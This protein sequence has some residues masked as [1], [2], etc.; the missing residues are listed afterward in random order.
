MIEENR[1]S[2]Q[3]LM[4]EFMGVNVAVVQEKVDQI[5][6]LKI[7]NL[8]LQS[9]ATSTLLKVKGTHEEIDHHPTTSICTHIPPRSQAFTSLISLNHGISG[10]P[11]QK[12]KKEIERSSL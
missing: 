1:N 12:E 11:P 2:I 6:E 5:G 10:T 4:L 7:S 9:G 8:V 3:R